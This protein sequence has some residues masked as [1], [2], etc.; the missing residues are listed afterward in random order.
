MDLGD[1]IA[2]YDPAQWEKIAGNLA[3]PRDKNAAIA[4]LLG[5]SRERVRQ[6]RKKQ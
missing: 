1:A 4:K 2:G 6:M 5:C 3:H